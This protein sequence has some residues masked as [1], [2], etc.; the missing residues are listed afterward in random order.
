[1]GLTTST[2]VQVSSN[3]MSIEA[4]KRLRT[5]ESLED[6]HALIARER[7]NASP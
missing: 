7:I 4:R 2:I 6:A 1:M 3:L 5:A